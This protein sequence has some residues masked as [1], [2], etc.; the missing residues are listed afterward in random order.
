M[1]LS[2]KY[3]T[4][5]TFRHPK[6][7]MLIAFLITISPLTGC[8]IFKGFAQQS[9][10]QEQTDKIPKP[11][12]EIEAAIEN[13]F[14]T[15]DGPTLVAK[16]GS[17][18]QGS[19]DSIQ[20]ESQGQKNSAPDQNNP[21]GQEGQQGQ[22]QQGQAQ[23]GQQSKDPWQQLRKDINSMHSSWNEYLPEV[24]AKGAK[25]DVIDGFSNALNNLTKVAEKKNKND[26]LQAVN[27]L[28]SH[29]PEIYAVYKTKVPPELKSIIYYARN[30][31]LS[32][33]IA[34]WTRASADMEEIKS[35]WSLVKNAVGEEQKEDSAKLDLSI[36]EL[37]KVI[38]DKNKALVE[39]K[40]QLTL[41]NIGS[42]QQSMEK[43]KNSNN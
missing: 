7:I 19:S 43:A 21:A 42:L 36:Y 39:I 23:K 31:V 15:L 37:E 10:Q 34:D 28:Y 30:A 18:Q 14:M 32:S 17:N 3:R 6:F 33:A 4:E 5:K 2:E 22:E 11:L 35:R 20:D 13:V 29:L 40:G 38:K 9:N 26:A 27:R 16:D 25:K 1:N 41:A 24:T 12:E 8:S